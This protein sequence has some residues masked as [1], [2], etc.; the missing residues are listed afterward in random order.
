M[1]RIAWHV[2][3]NR[4]GIEKTSVESGT[5]SEDAS[6]DGVRA[7]QDHYFWRRN[8]IVTNLKR[9]S[10]VFRNRSGDHNPITVTGRCQELDTESSHIKVRIAAGIQLLLVRI[11]PRRRNLA[12]FQGPTKERP[13]LV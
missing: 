4:V 1:R 2:Q 5:S 10:H 12:E 9:T 8:G 11:G 3:V 7:Y 13:D 6:T